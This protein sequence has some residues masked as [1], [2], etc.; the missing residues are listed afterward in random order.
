MSRTIIKIFTVIFF[1]FVIAL[2]GAAAWVWY[3]LQPVS[4]ATTA[5]ERF[6]I[7]RGQSVSATADKLV[8]A[9]LVKNALVF[10]LYARYKK[11]D[12]GLQAGSYK[13][14]PSM[15]VMA[16]S[17]ALTK[18]TEDTWIKL[19]EGWRVEE[20]ADY[21]ASNVELTEFKRADFMALAKESEGSVFPDSYLVSK[22]S[23][24]EQL[25]NLFTTTFQKRVVTGLEKELSAAP[26]Q[27]LRKVIILA[28]IVQREARSYEDMRRVAGILQN[29]IKIDMALNVD[30]TLQ[31]IQGYDTEE[32]KWWA[33]PTIA[34]KKSTSL[35]NTYAHP[36]LPPGP[37][38]NPGLQAIKAVLDPIES[39]DLFYLHAPTGKMYYSV[40]LEEHNQNVSRYLR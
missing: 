11:L 17:T 31:Y 7:A 25:F 16:L 13:L 10:R 28:S 29:R 12:T 14:S 36:G 1:L 23:T 18:G 20:I 2:C 38:C 21:L 35:Y 8:A 6:V 4:P 24:A 34:T 26:E 5:T 40:T 19:L 3:Q 30:A 22:E 32:K 39:N 15:S 33:A 27:D 9:G 37:I